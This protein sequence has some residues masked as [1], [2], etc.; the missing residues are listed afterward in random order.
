MVQ[1]Q[2]Y[3]QELASTPQELLIQPEIKHQRLHYDKK[4]R[5]IV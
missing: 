5:S 4:I 2:D 1:L 3:L